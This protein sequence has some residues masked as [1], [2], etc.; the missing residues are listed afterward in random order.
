[1]DKELFFKRVMQILRALWSVIIVVL[2]ILTVYFVIPLIYPFIIGW[3]IAYMLNP[4]VHFL[5]KRIK[6]PRWIATSLSLIIFFGVLIAL[7]TLLI[8]KIVIEVGKFSKMLSENIEFWVNDFIVYI[9]SDQL[10]NWMNQILFFYNQNSQYHQTIDQNINNV[11]D[12]LTNAVTYMIGFVIEGSIAIVSI[13]PNFTFGLIIGVLAAFFISKDWHSIYDWFFSFFPKKVSKSSGTV[14]KDLQKV[15]FGYIRAQLIMISITAV[16]VIVGLM[17]LD[18]NYALSIGLLIGLID[19]LPYLGVGLV[20]IPWIIY[21][22]IQGN[23]FLGVGL[24]ILYGVVLVVRSAIE[25]KV[26]G[27]SIGLNALATLVAMVVGLNLFGIIGIVIGP[28][29]LVMLLALHRADIF[30]DIAAY[31]RGV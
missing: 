8:S 5:E 1:M 12:H 15:L 18:V 7:F 21:T 16:F 2:L 19:L 17:I 24:S 26:L 31:I 10:Q 22:F 25:P 3:I 20:M 14:W 29:S 27:K 13:L 6:L 9:N 28:V 30:R 4:L 23:V 11:G